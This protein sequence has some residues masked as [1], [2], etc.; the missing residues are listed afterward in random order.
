[1]ND[2]IKKQNLGQFFTTN[3]DLIL[4]GMDV[5]V[6][7][8]NVCDPFAGNQDLMFW[9]EKNGCKSIKGFDYDK[10]YVDDKRVFFNDSINNFYPCEFVCTNPPYLHKNKANKIIKDVFFSGRN[11]MY[12]DLYQVSL[13]AISDS[14][15]GIVIVPLNFLCAENAKKIRES[16]FSKFTIEK[17]NIFTE[18]VFADTTYNVISFYYKKR[19]RHCDKI[20]INAT[21][22]PENKNIQLIIE[23][24]YN[25]QFGGDFINRIK[26]IKNYLGV[27]RLTEEYVQSGEYQVEMAFQNIKDRRIFKVSNKIKNLLDNNILFLRAIDSKNGTKI[28][29]ED[30]RKYKVNGLV[31]KSSSRN[32][33]HLIFKKKISLDEQLALMKKFNDELNYYRDKYFSFFLTN[34]RD[35]NRKR[36]SFDFAYKFLNYIYYEEFEKQP[37]LF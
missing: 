11:T 17:M 8:K 26:G 4:K 34:F 12:E 5:F 25:W 24:Q 10:K 21:I 29:L 14:K 23:R 1:M 19:N 3:S 36:L 28:Q 9:A 35:N 20:V 32:M 2:I 13:D 37:V 33:A 27:Y 6:K 31:G 15:E 22:Y 30:I 7:N 16:F 18:K